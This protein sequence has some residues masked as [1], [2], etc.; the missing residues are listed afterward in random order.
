M[1]ARV[2]PRLAFLLSCAIRFEL[3]EREEMMLDEAFDDI[4]RLLVAAP[5]LALEL[6]GAL[7]L[8]LDH[9]R[10]GFDF[11]ARQVQRCRLR[12]QPRRF[13]RQS[14]DRAL[15]GDQATRY[16]GLA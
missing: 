1:T 4:E 13:V 14:A 15:I 11:L 3:V 6:I 9:D 8:P 5:H 10:Q 2:D 7:A 16:R 12:L